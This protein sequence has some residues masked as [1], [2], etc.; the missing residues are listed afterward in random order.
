MWERTVEQPVD[1]QNPQSDVAK[2]LSLLAL[3]SKVTQQDVEF[4]GEMAA[5]KTTHKKTPGGIPVADL[6]SLVREYAGKYTSVQSQKSNV[7]MYTMGIEKANA[8]ESGAPAEAPRKPRRRQPRSNI[9]CKWHRIW[10]S[11]PGARDAVCDTMVQ[12]ELQ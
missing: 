9:P 7:A 1:F 2:A 10:V 3:T 8:V 5:L 4:A 11:A 6:I 12:L